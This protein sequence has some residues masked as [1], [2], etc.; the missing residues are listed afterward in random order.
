MR[1]SNTQNDWKVSKRLTLNLGLRWDYSG[2]LRERYDRLSQ[3]DLGALNIT[4][5]PG[6]YTFPN[7]KGNGPGRKDDSYKDF[8]PRV[9]FAY[10]PFNNTVVRSAYGISYDPVT[11]TGSG[12]LGFGADGFRSLSFL[13]IRPNSGEFALLDVLD[14]PYTNAYAG[15]GAPLGKNPDDPGFLGY[16]AIAVPRKEGGNPYMQQWNFTIEQKLPLDIDLQVAYVGTKGT[17]L[18]VNFTEIDGTNALPAGLLEQWRQTYQATSVNPANTRVANPFY[19]APPGTPL[20]GSGNPNVAGA[21]ITQL[22]LNRPYPAYPSVRLGYERYGSSSY[23]GMQITARRA[24]RNYVEMGGS[25]TWSKMIDTTTDNSAGAG[26][27]GAASDGAF[28]INNMKLD[29]SVS[30]FDVPQRLVIYSVWESPFGKGHSFLSGNRLAGGLLGGWKLSTNSQF[31]SGLPLGI[32]GGGFGR[33][34][35]VSNPVLPE[36]DRCYGPQTCKLPDGSSVFVAAGRQLYFNPNAFRNRVVQFGPGAGSNA[37]KYTDDIYWYGTSPRLLSNLRGWGVNNTD[38]SVSR[39]FNI[40]EHLKTTFRADAVNVFNQKSISD[41]GIDKS[42]GSS[43][44]PSNA[45]D[46]AQVA[47]AGQSLSSTF[48]TLDIRSQAISARYLQFALRVE[49]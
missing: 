21:T 8:A 17:H 13:R 48:G 34:D 20:I 12:I 11:G 26:N 28:S 46:P 23:N 49:F 43:Y 38:I 32:G 7:F 24:F 42:F 36:E 18:L 19:V 1:H 15:G 22:Q 41:G 47:R 37:G 10:R 40:R 45:N 33:P 35:L 31:Q 39:S 29:R 44:L 3:F 9:G 6:R 5:T 30:Q 4:G 16:N 14:R 25:Y 27:T 2:S